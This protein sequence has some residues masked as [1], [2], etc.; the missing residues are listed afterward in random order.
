MG[1]GQPNF[2]HNRGLALW[3][4]CIKVLLFFSSGRR[5]TGQQSKE[6]AA[7]AA[8]KSATHR[9]R[10][11]CMRKHTDGASTNSLCNT[12]YAPPD[13]KESNEANNEPLVASMAIGLSCQ[14]CPHTNTRRA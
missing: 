7:H 6:G 8:T 11:T 12:P 10:S 2:S 13:A 1:G 5:R 14:L 9:P 4:R 3:D